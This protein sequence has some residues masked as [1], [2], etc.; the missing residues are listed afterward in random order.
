VSKFQEAYLGQ[1]I[2]V[3]GSFSPGSF[4]AGFLAVTSGTLTLRDNQGVIEINA[5][6]VTAGVYTPMP[7]MTG[8][9]GSSVEL[10][11][12]ASGTLAYGS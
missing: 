4:I 3:N 5:V 1:P 8:G 9:P 10:A 11:G 12:G 7:F 6:P 2:G